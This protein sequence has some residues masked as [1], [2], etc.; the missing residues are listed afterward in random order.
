[1][2][3]DEGCAD[4]AHT[5]D[6]V[7]QR[8]VTLLHFDA[9]V[10]LWMHVWACV[11]S[12][13]VLCLILFHIPV[14]FPQKLKH[15]DIWIEISFKWHPQWQRF[16]AVKN[17][18]VRFT[19]L[20]QKPPKKLCHKTRVKVSCFGKMADTTVKRCFTRGTTS[21]ILQ[22]EIQYGCSVNMSS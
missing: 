16:E 14:S 22:V 19:Y 2:S 4:G 13:L 1:M 17:R 18:E 5:Q 12:F 21:V 20:K 8:E 9:L 3:V 10:Q 15:K 6:C 11:A 7:T